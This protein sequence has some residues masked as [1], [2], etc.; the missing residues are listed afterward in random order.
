[1]NRLSLSSLGSLF[2]AALF[3]GMLV[4]GGCS[5]NLT[6]PAPS[7]QDVTVQQETSGDENGGSTTPHAGRN[8]SNED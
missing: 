1:M 2:T 5:D 3:A 6:G 8:G 7:D 4:L